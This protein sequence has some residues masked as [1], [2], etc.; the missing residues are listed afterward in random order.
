MRERVCTKCGTVNDLLRSS[1]RSQS[2]VCA[3][4]G[5]GLFSQSGSHQPIPGNGPQKVAVSLIPGKGLGVLALVDIAKEELIERCPVM[6]VDLSGIEGELRMGPYEDGTGVLNLRHLLLP[7]VV[8]EHRCLAFGYGTFYNHA[9]SED[10]NAYY[11]PYVEESSNR[12]FIDFFAKTHIQAGE[13]VTQTYAPERNL[14]FR[15]VG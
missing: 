15:P 9:K 14:W 6:V 11:I 13:E 4:C 10:S 12:R 7:W 2:M 3:S 1:W 8:N 5:S